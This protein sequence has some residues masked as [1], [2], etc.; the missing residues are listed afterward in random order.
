MCKNQQGKGSLPHGQHLLYLNVQEM[1]K[2][3]CGLWHFLHIIGALQRTEK[4]ETDIPMRLVWEG[5]NTNNYTSFP[6]GSGT[7]NINLE[8]KE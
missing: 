6:N 1:G 2:V 8:D 4:L 3:Q 5:W 7:A